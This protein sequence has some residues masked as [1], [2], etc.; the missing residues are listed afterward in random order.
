[1]S[2]VHEDEGTV[3]RRELPDRYGA[4]TEQERA[5]GGAAVDGL[6]AATT[7]L[8]ALDRAAGD[9]VLSARIVVAAGALAAVGSPALMPVVG[10]PALLAANVV[11]GLA[12]VAVA[13]GRA[14]LGRAPAAPARLRAPTRGAHRP[15]RLI[16]LAVLGLAALLVLLVALGATAVAVVAA[17][18]VV[19]AAVVAVLAPRWWP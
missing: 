15:Q 5:H 14:D 10:G 16:A 13:W 19:L 7:R 12:L 11:A 3:L 2:P 17:A 18:A 4:L 6:L 9:A 8:I 1:M